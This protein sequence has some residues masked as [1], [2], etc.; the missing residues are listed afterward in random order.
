M[1]EIDRETPETTRRVLLKL[2]VK[3]T[4]NMLHKI[5]NGGPF[6]SIRGE[7]WN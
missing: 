1:H 5:T 6:C 3:E 2:K 4:R 7:Q